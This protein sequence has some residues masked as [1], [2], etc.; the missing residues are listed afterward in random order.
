MMGYDAYTVDVDFTIPADQV[1]TALAAVEAEFG[2]YASLADAVE[3]IT[4]FEDC[5][6]D[7]D[8][9]FSLGHHREK[10]LSGTDQ[11]LEILGRFATDG[12][13]VRFDGEDGALFGFRV[14]DGRLREESGDYVW[15]LDPERPLAPQRERWT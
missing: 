8:Q 9:W 13:Y 5:E 15:H 4:C 12:S 11:L 3:D 14:V 6:E 7:P 10:Y 1:P 2:S